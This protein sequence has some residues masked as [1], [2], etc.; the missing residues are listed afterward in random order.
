MKT[1]MRTLLYVVMLLSIIIPSSALAKNRDH[2]G[3]AHQ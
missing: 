3:H 2:Y 1:R